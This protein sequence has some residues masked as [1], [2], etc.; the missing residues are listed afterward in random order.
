MGSGSHLVPVVI[1]S[2]TV[3][4]I[5]VVTSDSGVGA[6]SIRGLFDN[7]LPAMSELM[8]GLTQR[9]RIFSP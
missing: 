3:G 8:A 6:V 4:F 5:P 9:F 2:S 1:S 7:P